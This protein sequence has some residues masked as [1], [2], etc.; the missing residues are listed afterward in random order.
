MSL[1]ICV[2]NVI[3]LPDPSV[4]VFQPTK[5]LFPSTGGAS[6]MFFPITGLVA[7]TFTVAYSILSFINVTVYPSGFSSLDNSSDRDG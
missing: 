4:F 5:I 7:S 1:S 3:L 2:S 6:G